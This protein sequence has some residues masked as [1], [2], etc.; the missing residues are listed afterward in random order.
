M[1]Q[2]ND[3]STTNVYLLALLLHICLNNT[4]QQ[5]INNKSVSH[6]LKIII[7]K[8]ENQ[9]TVQHILNLS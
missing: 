8:Q 7:K 5:C 3:E 9:F 1:E 6:W 2:N 4:L